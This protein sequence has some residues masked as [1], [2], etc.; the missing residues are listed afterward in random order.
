MDSTQLLKRLSYTLDFIR[1]YGTSLPALL[2]A[3]SI[4]Q[5]I[6]QETPVAPRVELM[7]QM[8][9]KRAVWSEQE[10]PSCRVVETSLEPYMYDGWPIAALYRGED[11]V[12]HILERCCLPADRSAIVDRLVRGALRSI[13]HPTVRP[14]IERYLGA[15]QRGDM[16]QARQALRNWVLSALAHVRAPIPAESAD[17][18]WQELI[19]AIILRQ[20][21]SL[22]YNPTVQALLELVPPPVLLDPSLITG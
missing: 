4:L 15:C 2:E 10:S 9:F 6:R 20:H 18:Y 11:H 14:V 17:R 19:G 8:T 21:E 12:V 13:A 16:L 1:E 5:Q 3:Q 7:S 22:P